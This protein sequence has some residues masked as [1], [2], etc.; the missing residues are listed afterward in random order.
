MGQQRT[1]S[2][3]ENMST[4]VKKLISLEMTEEY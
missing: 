1:P 4:M 3:D 2:G